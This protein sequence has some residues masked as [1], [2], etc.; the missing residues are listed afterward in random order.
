MAGNPAPAR[1]LLQVAAPWLLLRCFSPLCF[2]SQ[3]T[4][5]PLPCL[6]CV[7]SAPFSS[8]PST[9]TGNI[10][11]RSRCARRPIS[12]SLRR[13]YSASD[14]ATTKLQSPRRS[15]LLDGKNHLRQSA[16]EMPL[17]PPRLGAFLPDC[18]DPRRRRRQVH[19][20]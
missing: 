17:C 20:A 4:C 13:S 15:L 5:S 16:L 1:Q 9:G 6:R 18:P 12:S 8:S 10:F 7:L 19:S 14:E 3:A 2:S 11:Y